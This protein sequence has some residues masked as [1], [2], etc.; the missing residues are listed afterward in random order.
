VLEWC[1][2]H[3]TAGYGVVPQHRLTMEVHLGRFLA[4]KEQVHHRNHVRHDN[5]LDNLVLF[6][7]QSAHMRAHHH[8]K[9]RRDPV[10]IARV[11]EV[12]ADPSIPF[13]DLGISTG[14]LSQ[15]CRESG[16][17]WLSRGN[18][19]RAAGLTEATA[20][21]AL[22]GRSVLEAAQML[23]LHPMTLYKRFPHLM[24]KRTTPGFLDQH[25]DEVLRLRRTER[26][27]CRDIGLRFGVS[28]GC[29]MKSIRR[30]SEQGAIPGVS[31]AREIPRTRPGPKPGRK[32][33]GM[34]W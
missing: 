31:D 4:R 30:W 26:L 23:K 10:L 18:R 8:G 20:R 14:S 13:V 3:P 21:E 29:A 22:Q 33:Q 7:D 24:N 34:A 27:S 17:T 16:I 28:E 11:R 12:A 6:E 32:R 25:M 19:G 9:G 15:I 5:R 1:P 2:T